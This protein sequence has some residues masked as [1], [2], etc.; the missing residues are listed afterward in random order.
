MNFI[1]I[2]WEQNEVNEVPLQPECFPDLNLDQVI[3]AITARKQEYNLKPLYYTPPNDLA[4]IR[5][6][7]EIARD[8]NDET[9]T[10]VLKAFAEQMVRVRRYIALSD[11]LDHRYHKEGW[12]LEA[13]LVYGK[14]LLDLGEGISSIPLSSRGLLAF[15]EFVHRSLHSQTF[16]SFFSEAR[17]VKDALQ[18]IRYCIILQNGTV[19][20][21]RYEGEVDYSLEVEKSFAKFKQ[22]AVK[23]Y[24]S[25][26]ARSSGMNHVEAQILDFVARLFPEEFAALDRFYRRHQDFVDEVISRFD[27]EIQFYLAYLDF[28][29]EIQR[30][31][32]NFCLPEV[33]SEKNI[34]AHQTFDLALAHTFRFEKQ[35]IVPNDFYLRD[36][37]RVIIVTGPNQGGKTTFARMFGQLHYLAKLGLPVPGKDARLFLCD[38]IFTHFERQEDLRNLSG[39]L[40]D[41]LVRIRSILDRATSYS[42]LIL[43]E[44]FSSTTF[45]DAVFLSKEIMQKISS[46]DVYC[47]WVTFLD[48]LSTFNEKTV[49]MVSTVKPDNAV[50]RTYKIIRQ[51]ADGLAYAFSLAEKHRLTYRQIV[52]RIRS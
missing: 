11:K 34:A 23:D 8:L 36:S 39:K 47:I 38:Q 28:I 13:A 37:E 41:D 9:L 14:A 1:S 20:V 45:E 48:E 27:R 17:K 46:L 29:A 30:K 4:T 50:E 25:D 7:Q 51:P 5:Y 33:V 21:R 52:E 22:G 3:Q 15:R 10:G 44:V 19:R 6:R 40:H 2:L 18:R 24:H 31:G 12:F 35:E 43:N 49:S 26:L 42:I 16:E 32:L